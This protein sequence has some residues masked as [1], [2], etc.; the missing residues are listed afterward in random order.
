[1][2]RGQFGV[3]EVR[4]RKGFMAVIVKERGHRTERSLAHPVLLVEEDEVT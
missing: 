4:E 1:M 3:W 2:G